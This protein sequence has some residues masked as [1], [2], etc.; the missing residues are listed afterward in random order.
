MGKVD[1]R[2]IAESFF[3][4]QYLYLQFSRLLY[5]T[6]LPFSL[7]QPV[8][9]NISLIINKLIYYM[10]YTSFLFRSGLRQPPQRGNM[11][12]TDETLGGF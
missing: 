12:Q 11:S 10:L 5:K 7:Y 9:L 3:Q 2:T 4:I 1:A 6:V 8:H